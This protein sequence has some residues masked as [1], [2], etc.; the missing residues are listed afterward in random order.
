MA[1]NATP[2]AV[3]GT[4][5]EWGTELGR[6]FAFISTSHL[7]LALTQ[8]EVQVGKATLHWQGA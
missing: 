8:E 2:F 5:A 3:K 4:L 6:P 7:V 1:C